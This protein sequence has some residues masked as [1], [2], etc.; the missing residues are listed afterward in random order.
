MPRSYCCG[1]CLCSENCIDDW[2]DHLDSYVHRAHVRRHRKLLK[3]L[4]RRDAEIRNVVREWERCFACGSQRTD[5]TVQVTCCYC[6]G[7]GGQSQ[8]PDGVP[9]APYGENSAP[10][11]TCMHHAFQPCHSCG[12]V[13][14][15][16][17]YGIDRQ[18][19]EAFEEA[20]VPK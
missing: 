15:I 7:A 18:A 19:F 3:A 12:A 5:T 9:G 10:R 6:N 13:L 11:Y 2:L 16:E 14:G 20:S 8:D 4:F 1:V 17:E